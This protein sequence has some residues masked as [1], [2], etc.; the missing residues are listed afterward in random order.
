MHIRTTQ[1]SL[2]SKIEM[3]IKNHTNFT[4]IRHAVK[5][6]NT[7]RCGV[8]FQKQQKRKK[9]RNEKRRWTYHTSLP[10]FSIPSFQFQVD[11]FLHLC[12]R[13][14]SIIVFS[15]TRIRSLLCV[16]VNVIDMLSFCVQTAHIYQYTILNIPEKLT[17]TKS[18][19]I[20]LPFGIFI[21]FGKAFCY[22]WIRLSRV[23]GDECV[24]M[25]CA[26]WLN[27]NMVGRAKGWRSHMSSPCNACLSFHSQLIEHQM[28][29]IWIGGRPY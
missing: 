2:E 12:L 19:V 25:R 21:I 22:Y 11:L 14:T 29:D 15:L 23:G 26:L 3:R 18:T 28:G 13:W 7:K 9:S 17:D 10:V 16:R 24:C 20:K 5:T 6:I 4:L 27:G 8:T 1:I